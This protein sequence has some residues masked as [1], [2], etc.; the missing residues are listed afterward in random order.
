MVHPVPISR[1]L[2][3]SFRGTGPLCHY[4]V[5]SINVKLQAHRRQDSLNVKQDPGPQH[6]G[7]TGVESQQRNRIPRVPATI[8]EFGMSWWFK[9]WALSNS[10]YLCGLGHILITV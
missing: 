7:P 9:A 5:T 4:S 10:H 6:M 1:N 8:Q 2:R 3:K